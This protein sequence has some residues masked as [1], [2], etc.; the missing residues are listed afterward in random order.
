MTT[1]DGLYNIPEKLNAFHDAVCRQG[2]RRA[3]RSWEHQA[4][5]P[6][7]NPQAQEAFPD[8]D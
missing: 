7:A 4:R 2:R 5:E 3:P 6:A 8:L 1:T